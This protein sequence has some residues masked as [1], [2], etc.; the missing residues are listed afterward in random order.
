[1]ISVEESQRRLN[2]NK[3]NE[4]VSNVFISVLIYGHVEE[5]ELLLKPFII[6]IQYRLLGDLIRDIL[7]HESRL[8]LP[9]Q[10]LPPNYVKLV[11]VP[12]WLAEFLLLFFPL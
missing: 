9:H 8:V 6:N 5:V 1:M 2:I 11:R 12:Y 7:D 4:G 3:I 10:N